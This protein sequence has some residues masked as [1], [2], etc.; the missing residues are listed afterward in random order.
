M[1]RGH[2]TL[3]WNGTDDRGVA[4]GA[5]IYFYRLETSSYSAVKSMTLLR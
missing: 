4:V 5:G 2:F 3:A 1:D